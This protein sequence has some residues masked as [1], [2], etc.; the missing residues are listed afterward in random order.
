MAKTLMKQ[1]R[2]C[3]RTYADDSLNFCL[4]D[5]TPLSA[6]YD[7][8]A[9]RIVS[10]NPVPSPIVKSPLQT[11][12]A[13]QTLR[14]PLLYVIVA[15][16][17]LIAGGGLVALL[18]SEARDAPV[19]QRPIELSPTP[20]VALSNRVQEKP[21]EGLRLK[22]TPLPVDSDF[23]KSFSGFINNKYGIKMNIR[24]SG[25]SLSGTYFYTRHN[26]TLNG[27]IDG[28]QNVELYGYDEAGTMIDI[29]KGQL[30]SNNLEGTWSKPDGSKSLPFALRAAK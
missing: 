14:N 3:N 8:E 25:N 28:N 6:L 29:F 22:P 23:N 17:A 2:T 1:C 19:R 12:P 30:I 20:V 7:Q 15:L 16:L 21:K 26:I 9:T 10:P 11:A 18:R 5:G 4:E 24:R 27:T 13:N